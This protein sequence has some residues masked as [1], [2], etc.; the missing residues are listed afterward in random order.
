MLSI[1][2]EGRKYITNLRNQSV[3]QDLALDSEGENYEG[4]EPNEEGVLRLGECSDDNTSSL[5]GL[6][7]WQMGD[8]EVFHAE[9]NMLQIQ[10]SQSEG[11]HLEEYTDYKE[12]GAIKL[13]TLDNTPIKDLV[14]RS[15]L[16]AYKDRNKLAST[17]FTSAEK[18]QVRETK[19]TSI[20]G[21]QLELGLYKEE[22]QN[23]LA[24]TVEKAP[25]AQAEKGT[26]VQISVP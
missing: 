12:N 10:E 23:I 20:E 15:K 1:E 18:E 9:C 2:T 7:H 19:S 22:L 21:E 6:F 16:K 25:A 26:P 3:S 8:C 11:R 14:N 17:H 24:I 13:S 4:M 5:N